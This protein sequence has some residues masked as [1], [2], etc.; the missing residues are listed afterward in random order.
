MN[1]TI[2]ASILIAAVVFTACSSNESSVNSDPQ[3]VM[4]QEDIVLSKL[5]LEELDALFSNSKMQESVQSDFIEYTAELCPDT[6]VEATC[7]GRFDNI[8]NFEFFHFRAEEGAT[9]TIN[10]DRVSCDFDGG[11]T[12]YKNNED[13]A[14]DVSTVG[15]RWRNQ[16]GNG[17]GRDMRLLTLNDDT[18]EPECGGCG[19]DPEITYEIQETGTYTVAVYRT[20]PCDDSQDNTFEITVSG[21]L[22]GDDCVADSDGDGIPDDEDE[23][24][25]SD[26]QPIITI[27][28]CDSGIDNI[29]LGDGAFMMDK[30]NECAENAKN[31]GAFVSCVSSLTND[32][33]KEGLISGNQKSDITGCASSANIP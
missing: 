2:L 23:Y 8:D 10:V 24:P 14:I 29:D 17:G 20:G 26:T 4:S 18:N 25:E 12:L 16:F 6:P 5:S 22:E 9:I 27:D 28:G 13:D 21:S 15:V 33:K 7:G 3:T 31:H 11:M 30:I 1:A 32:W 19:E